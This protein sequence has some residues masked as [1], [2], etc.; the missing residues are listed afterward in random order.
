MSKLSCGIL[1]IKDCKLLIG[2]V[3]GQKHWD[4][5]KGKIEDGETPI[6]AAIRETYEEAGIVVQETELRDLGQHP[7]RRGKQIHLFVYT[8][9][10]PRTKDCIEAIATYKVKELDDFQYNEFGDL[11]KFLNERMMR[12][13]GR[14]LFTNAIGNI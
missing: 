10:P 8:G 4:I 5:P 11:H 1:F 13:L 12:A 2:H 6:Q 14:A 9:N 3:T 7:Y